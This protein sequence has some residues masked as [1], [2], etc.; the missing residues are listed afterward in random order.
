M[1][2]KLEV[3][4]EVKDAPDVIEIG[5]TGL[6]VI[7]EALMQNREV[8]SVL[9]GILEGRGISGDVHYSLQVIGANLVKKEAE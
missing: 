2:R 4:P 1:P 9:L 7:S 8:R 6:G 5:L 3:V